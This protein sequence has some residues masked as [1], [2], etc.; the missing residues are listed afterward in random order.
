MDA[1]FSDTANPEELDAP[2]LLLKTTAALPA[3]TAANQ[4]KSGKGQAAQ[5]SALA[6]DQ[7]E[8]A[9]GSY[10]RRNRGSKRRQNRNRQ[11]KSLQRKY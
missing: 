7:R 6:V 8:Q 9:G 11:I 10:N 4:R 3:V 1:K 5:V 2:D